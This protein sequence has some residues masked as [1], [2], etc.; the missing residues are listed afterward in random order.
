MFAHILYGGDYNPE[1]WTPD[2]WEEDARLM[3]AAGVNMVTLGVFAWAKLE[4]EPGRYDFEW[5]DQVMDLLHAH[6]V[7]VDLATA[8][9]S[10]PPWLVR[11][12]PAILP[13][14][15]DG[16][17]LW[18]GSRRHYCPHNQDYRKQAVDFVTRLA[19]HVR[20]HPALAL[21]HIDNEYA[22]H[23]SECFCADSIEAFRQ[24]L[25]Q[26]YGSLDA[27][28]ET[29]GTAFWG[30]QYGAWEEINAPRRTPSSVNPAQRL[31]W[32]RF[33]SD[34][35]LAC[36]KDQKSVLRDITPHIPVTTN[37]MGFFKPLDYWE[38]AA[39]EDVVANDNYPDPGDPAW[40]VRS[41][42]VCDLMRS[43]GNGRPW[44]LM[45]QAPGQVNWRQR[46][47][48]KRP[49]QMRLGSYQVLA[50]GGNGIM[51]FQWRASRAGSEKFHSGMVPHVGTDSRVWREVKKLGEELPRLDA[52]LSSRVQSEVAILFDWKNWWAF[53]QGDKPSNDLRL[54]PLIEALY[55]ELFRRNITVDFARPDADL[56]P[57]RLVIAPHLYLMD[58]R[59]AKNIGRFVADGGTLLMT[60]FSGIVDEADRVLLGGYP[61]LLRDVLGLWV[62]E[63]VVYLESQTNQ[64]ETTEGHRFACNLWSDIVHPTD[65]EVL[66]SYREDYFSG[67]PAVTRHH[68]GEGTS[69]YLGTA[70]TKDGLKWLFEHILEDA[71]VRS[72][73]A[74]SSDV[75][76]TRR[77]DGTHTWMFVLN[78]SNDEANVELSQEGM[79]VITGVP[80]KASLVLEPKGVAII[81]LDKT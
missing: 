44:L 25:Q 61:V 19:R 30:Q 81:Q 62:E 75:E 1:Q 74:V 12:H 20:D 29:W 7:R 54:L 78:H 21:W 77:S 47:L 36:F 8:T 41:G 22:C 33:Y 16:V 79:D 35:W 71:K 14:T 63:F 34:S 45:E 38:W 56:T 40:M 31:D 50:R 2:I 28:N 17:T 10:P 67:T 26:R 55:A 68:F 23:V 58:D 48:I 9:A 65:A 64:V 66:A 46:N 70:L 51:D 11:L 80:V 32:Q 3:Q 76:I 73:N 57:Y 43:L 24:W 13:V 18:H 49:G 52:L 59:A 5:L 42:M 60:F 37:F 6:G 53:E 72:S 15:V 39:Q 69:Y 4:P 27:L